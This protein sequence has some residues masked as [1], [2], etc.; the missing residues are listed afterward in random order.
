MKKWG[1]SV[2]QIVRYLEKKVSAV[3]IIYIAIGFDFNKSGQTFRKTSRVIPYFQ[4]FEQCFSRNN[5]VLLCRLLWIVS[6]KKIV[7]S[8]F[9]KGNSDCMYGE[10]RVRKTRKFT[11]TQFSKI[12]GDRFATPVFAAKSLILQGKSKHSIPWN[13]KKAVSELKLRKRTLFV[14]KIYM[15]IT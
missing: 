6:A 7:N 12:S 8:D 3:I 4:S 2:P 1:R 15:S 13:A 5:A 10:K 14:N 9:D 11:A